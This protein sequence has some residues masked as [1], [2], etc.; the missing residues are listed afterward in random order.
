MSDVSLDGS[1][2]FSIIYFHSFL[3][4]IMM[5]CLKLTPQ[6]ERKTLKNGPTIIWSDFKMLLWNRLIHFITTIFCWTT[7]VNGKILAT[8]IVIMHCKNIEASLFMDTYGLVHLTLKDIYGDTR[9]H[10]DTQKFWL[11]RMMG[12][13]FGMLISPFPFYFPCL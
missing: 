9:S 10:E 12:P 2:S 5:L 1:I 4:S 8:N 7:K 6:W 13:Y 11:G 3:V